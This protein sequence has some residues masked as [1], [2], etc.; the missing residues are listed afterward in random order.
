MKTLYW[1]AGFLPGKPKQ[2]RPCYS[3]DMTSRV[4]ST[5]KRKRQADP[6]QSFRRSVSLYNLHS[7]FYVP[8]LQH[9]CARIVPGT[10]GRRSTRHWTQETEG[11]EDHCSHSC[12]RHHL[13]CQFSEGHTRGDWKGT[14]SQEV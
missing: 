1:S 8:H 13:Q 14:G 10:E 4:S 7:T 12:C 9:F 3:R 6:D 11:K 2:R 5:R